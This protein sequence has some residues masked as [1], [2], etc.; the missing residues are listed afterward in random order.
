MKRFFIFFLGAFLLSL[1]STVSLSGL[2]D[3]NPKMAE[4]QAAEASLSYDEKDGSLIF[5]SYPSSI[6]ESV[7]AE[8]V[9][10]NGLEFAT[11]QYIYNGERYYV[12]Y[13]VPDLEN[14]DY[15]L[16]TGKKGS[17]LSDALCAYKYE[18]I[19][20]HLLK[21][22]LDGSDYRVYF[23]ATIIDTFYFDGNGNSEYRSS[24]LANYL[25]N[26]FFDLA[27]T[28]EEQALLSD[29]GGDNAPY[30]RIP[31]SEYELSYIEEYSDVIPTL[32]A[33]SHGLS[34][35]ID[36][37]YYH[38]P[39]WSDIDYGNR[40]T[41]Q[42][43][44]DSQTNC[45]YDDPKIG[46]LPIIKLQGSTPITS[47][48]ES[49]IPSS[50]SQGGGGGGGGSSTKNFT[51]RGN[52][53]LMIVGFVFMG[54]GLIALVLTMKNWKAKMKLDHKFRG[55]PGTYVMIG[56]FLFVLILGVSLF[57]GGTSTISF[58]LPGTSLVG[59]YQGSQ[60]VGNGDRYYLGLTSNHQVY[61]YHGNESTDGANPIY[62]PYPDVGRWES[63]GD[64]LIIHGCA[65]WGLYDWENIDMSY[66]GAHGLGSMIQYEG[67]EGGSYQWY[68]S[69]I[70]FIL[71][72][73]AKAMGSGVA[74]IDILPIV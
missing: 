26:N 12:G 67:Y 32:Y 19:H 22:A 68:H 36:G 70:P 71:N 11:N 64:K 38:S 5:G 30:V 35:H 47:S 31:E 42:W 63:S 6:D 56:I 39:Y 15:I 9:L 49:S 10:T 53:P 48:E 72:H 13:F 54:G 66:T 18:P 73:G 61:R 44:N 51:F 4:A 14:D 21:P 8:E 69:L 55:R 17:E 45:L 20:W 57:V 59:Y 7:S 40:K 46:A 2:K 28:S 41:V 34:S 37:T 62:Y 33:I 43:V 1:G 52:V 29:F 74:H 27:F 50:S 23:S 65:S 60:K 16:K 58:G 3:N 25:N 24:T